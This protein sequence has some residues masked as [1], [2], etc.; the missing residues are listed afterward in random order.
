MDI[1]SEILYTVFYT[2]LLIVAFN[3]GKWWERN[4]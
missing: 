2:I 4:V 3:L 1:L